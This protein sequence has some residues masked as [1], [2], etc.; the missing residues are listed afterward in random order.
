MFEAAELGRKLDK[1]A[2]R[3][4]VPRL[5]TALLKA[6]LSLRESK[7]FPVIVLIA[8]VDGAGKG[9]TVNTLN[10][11][12][13]PR[14]IETHA[15]GAPTDE[16]RDRPP[17][18]RFWRVLP[19]K[20]RL[21][22]LFG[23]WYTEPIRAGADAL[24]DGADLDR[25]VEEINRLEKMLADEGVLILK[26]WF[27]LSKR[28]QRK[29]LKEL[30][31]SPAQRRRV[32]DSDWPHS[33]RY[34]ELRAVSEHVVRRTNKPH[35]HWVLVEGADARYRNVKV[36]KTVLQALRKRLRNPTA[37][38]RVVMP[39]RSPRVSDMTVLDGLDLDRALERPDYRERLRHYQGRLSL[40]SR[41]G[42]MRKRAVV[43]VFE[44]NDAA[45][46][47]GAIRRATAA[48]DARFYRVVPISA[49]TEEELAQP[50]LWRFWRRLPRLGHM[51]I[52][53]RSWYGRV[54]VE[55]VEGLAS[56]TDWYRAYSEINDFEEEMAR[57]RIVLAKFWLAIDKDEQ[58]RRFKQRAKTGFKRHKL[59]EEDWRNR[60]KWDAYVA[61]IH[62][63]VVQTSTEVAPW[64]LVEANDKY[65]A[66]IKVL[67]TLCERIEQ[68][69]A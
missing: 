2:Y 33:R 35:A 28:Q 13:D 69:L 56:E 54:L 4:E 37:R 9:E 26:F 42:K 49:P 14:E 25:S 5:R 29:R 58:E 59:T 65:Y 1:E 51:T 47:G 24:A 34:D 15:L 55:R 27:H 60:E 6:Q 20:G 7:A 68:G 30:E 17:L 32:G 18:W 16:E 46:K 11:W 12:M 40:L 61:A 53:D 22:I 38:P 31:K 8:G 63:M 48:L 39:S 43:A 62:D 50:Y 36:G 57:H 64:T 41:R 66:R 19:P 10:E 52:F 45:G 67:R 23:S 44:G 3:R 21:A